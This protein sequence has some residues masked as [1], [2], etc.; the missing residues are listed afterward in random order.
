MRSS[1]ARSLAPAALLVFTF[2]AHAGSITVVGSWHLGESDSGA[3]GG[4]AVTTSVDSSGNGVNLTATGGS[5]SPLYNTSNVAPHS[6]TAV[7]FS[8]SSGLAG[9]PIPTALDNWGIEVWAY[10]ANASQAAVVIYNGSTSNGGYG[11]YQAGSQWD[12]LFGGNWLGAVAPVTPN[13]W[14]D[15]ALVRSNGVNTFYINGVAYPATSGPNSVTTLGNAKML[16]GINNV[17]GE[18]FSGL[19]DEGR[20]FTFTGAF[21]PANL[22]SNTLSFSNAAGAPALTPVTTAALGILLLA[23]ALLLLRRSRHQS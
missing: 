23:S 10:P 2:A 16:L 6:S 21:D 3:T 15:L 19:L 11:I 7:A 1:V 17:G 8:G 14:V 5:P 9:A 12:F 4:Q 13:Q 22:Y 20:L 18:K